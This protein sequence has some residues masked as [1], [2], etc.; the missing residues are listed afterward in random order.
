MLYVF[1]DEQMRMLCIHFLSFNCDN[2]WVG[3][4][5]YTEYRN[6][7][8]YSHQNMYCDRQFDEDTYRF[9][10]IYYYPEVSVKKSKYIQ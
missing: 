8:W 7:S 1:T 2:K 9:C 6:I 3:V 5:R 4:K 10:M